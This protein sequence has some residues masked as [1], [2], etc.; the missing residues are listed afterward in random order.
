MAEPFPRQPTDVWVL[1]AVKMIRNGL[2]E[3]SLVSGDEANVW[4]NALKSATLDA[5]HAL[6]RI[7]TVIVEVTSGAEARSTLPERHGLAAVEL[8]SDGC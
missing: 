4:L 7:N 1:T 8:W 3:D 6:D 5:L 2:A